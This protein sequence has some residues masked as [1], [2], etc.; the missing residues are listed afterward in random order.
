M[1]RRGYFA[2]GDVIDGFGLVRFQSGC[3]SRVENL[4]E[5]LGQL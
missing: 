5:L 4:N 3:L 1:E 2:R